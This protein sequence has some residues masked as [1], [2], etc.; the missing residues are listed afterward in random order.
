M[1]KIQEEDF[2]LYEGVFF[3]IEF[4]FDDRGRMISK[5]YFDKVE[6]LI[7]VKLLAL[8]K[9]IAENGKLFDQ[10]KFRI[11]NKEYKIYEFKVL[12]ER[13]FSFFYKDNKIILTNAYYK[14]DQKVSRKDLLI[15]INMKRN[16]EYRLLKGEYYV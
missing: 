11:V 3:R 10:D 15:A 2:V 16:Y 4:Y 1:K 9:Y 6:Y 8:V 5:E 14:K 13:F 7:K 12:K